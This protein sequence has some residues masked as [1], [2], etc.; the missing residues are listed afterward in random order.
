MHNSKIRREFKGR[1][2]KQHK[3]TFTANNV[4]NLFM[5]YELDRWSKDSDASF[6]SKRLLFGAVGLTKNAN[7][8]KHFYSGYDI[9]FH[10]LFFS[11]KILLG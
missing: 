7:L 1:C 5:V 8:D 4:V 6:Y 9:G 10:S 3:V 2:L 11:S